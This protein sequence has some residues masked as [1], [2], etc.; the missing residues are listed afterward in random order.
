MACSLPGHPSESGRRF[1]ELP[2]NLF[3]PGNHVAFRTSSAWC[4]QGDFLDAGIAIALQIVSL[5]R[6]GIRRDRELDIGTI[7]TIRLQQ[8]IATVPFNRAIGTP[9]LPGG[10]DQD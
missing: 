9:S 3:K 2:R 7:A 5:D 6:L 10:E 4:Q 1:N 8:F